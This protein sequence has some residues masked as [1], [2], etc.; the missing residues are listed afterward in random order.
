MTVSGLA[1]GYSLASRTV[2][3]DPVLR[4]GLPVDSLVHPLVASVTPVGRAKAAP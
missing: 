2:G 3:E 1:S 4:G